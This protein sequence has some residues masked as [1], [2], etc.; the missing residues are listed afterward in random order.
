MKRFTS[1]VLA[2]ALLLGMVTVFTGA[3]GS[4][5]DPLISKS[6]VT[7]TFMQDMVDEGG[8]WVQLSLEKL[9]DEKLQEI[10]SSGY[11]FVSRYTAFPAKSNATVQIP[12]GGSIILLSGS[13]KVTISSGTVIDVSSGTEVS[14]GAALSPN[15]RYFSAEKTVAVYTFTADSTCLID[16]YYAGSSGFAGADGSTS[17]STKFTDVP[18]TAW[19]YNAVYYAYDHG[20]LVGTGGGKFSP[21]ANMTRGM[22]AVVLWHLSGNQAPSSIP[23]FNDLTANWYKLAIAWAKE[24]NVV[25]GYSDT[26][27]G[28]NDN[29][30]REQLMLILYRYAKMYG[31]DTSNQDATAFNAFSDKG[32]VSNY[33]KEAMIWGTANKIIFGSNGKLMPK[34]ASTRAQ[35]T[36]LILRFCEVF[37]E[38]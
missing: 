21:N 35:V 25:S 4:A 11:Q 1:A 15:V 20:L 7:K 6:Y 26:R 2:L 14:S 23:S 33:A 34:D 31:Y 17:S 29:I 30:T 13:A 5:S 28:P 38:N 24:N 3:A 8:A 16:G 10:T 12:T 9:Y 22:V 37:V 32:S 27:F 19:Y 18:E 36:Q